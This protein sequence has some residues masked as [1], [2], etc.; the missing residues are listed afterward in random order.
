M[1]S[2]LEKNINMAGY[3]AGRVQ[4]SLALAKDFCVVGAVNFTALISYLTENKFSESSEFKKEFDKSASTDR[5]YVI[6]FKNY[7]GKYKPFGAG[8]KVVYGLDDTKSKTN[9]LV[10]IDGFKNMFGVVAK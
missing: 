2:I 10:L 8:F 6:G 9:Q 1:V 5:A 4:I 3:S 7:L